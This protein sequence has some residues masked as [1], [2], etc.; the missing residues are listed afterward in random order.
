MTSIDSEQGFPAQSDETR[1]CE[2]CNAAMTLI[3]RLPRIL[4]RPPVQVYR[5]FSCNN[6]VSAEH[7]LSA[8]PSRAATS[9]DA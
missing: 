1:S 7:G 6:V 5:C 2:T 4:L 9:P 3:G 8:E